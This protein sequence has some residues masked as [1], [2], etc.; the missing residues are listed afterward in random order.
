MAWGLQ[1][2]CV[3]VL[4]M[5]RLWGILIFLLM[6]VVSYAANI[7]CSKVGK[8][9]ITKQNFDR[10]DGIEGNLINYTTHL[11]PDGS[12]YWLCFSYIDW[13]SSWDMSNI[14]ALSLNSTVGGKPVY[15]DGLKLQ[16][17]ASA[18]SLSGMQPIILQNSS[19]SAFSLAK[20]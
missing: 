12:A 13:S 7:D 3:E 14:P 15:I 1:Y 2:W 16:K 17:T 4:F 18:V 8:I 11:S 5:K 6:P 19:F 10:N 9:V 20:A